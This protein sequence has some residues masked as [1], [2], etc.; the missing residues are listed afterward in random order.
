MT[1]PALLRVTAIGFALGSVL[2]PVGCLFCTDI[3][4]SG[5][6]AWDAKPADDGVV[7]PG[8]YRFAIEL[9]DGMYTIECT[10]AERARE[11]ECVG[12]SAEDADEFEL[13]IELVSRQTSDE[14][15][16]DAPVGGFVVRA[17][18]SEGED[19]RSTRG[20]QAVHIDL[21]RDGDLLVD[22]TYDIDYERDEDFYGNE[23]CGFCDLQESR[24]ATWSVD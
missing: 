2:A 5:G 17:W 11:S 19:E 18:A 13:D 6:F 1:I 12:P 21:E 3:A 10:V 23:R 8:S 9:D 22:S 15:D 7:A 4:C 20:P 14:W 16:R 24:V